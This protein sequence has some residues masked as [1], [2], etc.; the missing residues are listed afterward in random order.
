MT[1]STSSCENVSNMSANKM[2]VSTNQTAF[3]AQG[4]IQRRLKQLKVR[5]SILQDQE[6]RCSRAVL[7]VKRKRY[8]KQGRGNIS[9][10]CREL[11]NEEKVNNR[12]EKKL[13]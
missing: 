10:A 9:N 13:N 12:I 8:F 1:L 4:R 11:I 6:L 3:Q 7:A 5:F 2:L